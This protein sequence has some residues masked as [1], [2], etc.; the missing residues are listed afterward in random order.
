VSLKKC[1]TGCASDT[2]IEAVLKETF[3][4]VVLVNSYVDF[5]DYDKT[6]KTYMD[7]R[8]QYKGM[9]GYNKRIKLYARENSVELA[10]SLFQYTQPENLEF[11][12]V[13]NTDQDIQE[14]STWNNYFEVTLMVD[15]VKANYKRVVFSFF[16]LV[17]NLG[18]VFEILRAISSLS[19]A[20]FAAKMLRFSIFKRLYHVEDNAE[21]DKQNQNFTN[22]MRNN[23]SLR[24]YPTMEERKGNNDPF[25]DKEDDPSK[26]P[27]ISSN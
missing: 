15:P 7:D 6:V 22:K 1:Q 11:I 16:D 17:G 26:S 2:V 12:S 14:F 4:T 18:G 3:L 5:G 25:Y 23:T 10:D 9:P 8:Y 21:S 24:V 27:V 19:V 13:E 20:L